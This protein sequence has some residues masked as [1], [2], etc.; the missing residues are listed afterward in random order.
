VLPL[1][2]GVSLA[3]AGAAGASGDAITLS[4]S[5]THPSGTTPLTITA[6]GSTSTANELVIVAAVPATQSQ[7]PSQYTGVAGGYWIDQQV[8]AT[9]TFSGVQSIPR[10]I[11][12]GSYD[13]CGWLVNQSGPTIV[14]TATP[15]AV[16]V[17]NPDSLTV[18]VAPASLIDGGSANV[19]VSGVADVDNPEVYVTEKPASEGGCA[20]AP[21]LD[22]GTPL[23]D[24]D[25]AFVNYD[26]FSDSQTEYPGNG[27]S[28]PDA[29]P[30]G[31]YT[32][33][34]WLIDADGSTTQPLAPV[35]EA[36]VTLLPPAGT[37]AF[38]VPE[39]VQ[40]GSRF[41]V[42]AD[43]ST[44][45]ADVGMYLDLK[46]LPARGPTCAASESLEPR[47]AQ[48]VIDDG[49]ATSTTASA[50]V[51][52]AGVYIACAWLEWP[53]GTIDG[54]FS[55]RFVALGSHQRPV[56]YSG[57][58]SQRLRHAGIG[59]ESVDGQVLS[60]TY[61]ARFACS[62]RGHKT[63][64]PVYATTFPAFGLTKGGR[65]ADTF[66][67]GNDHAKVAGRLRGRSAR[68]TFSEAY[69]S[70]GYACRSGTVSFTARRGRGSALDA[71]ET[72]GAAAHDSPVPAFGATSVMYFSRSASV[73]F[74]SVSPVTWL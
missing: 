49:H 6:A 55:G 31:R 1:A 51:R 35:A 50:K 13:I 53:H 17:S 63:S 44:G 23:A 21:S 18:S 54:P 46:P 59:F 38:S 9:G 37:L 25:P 3:F 22:R 74:W 7:C 34:G 36:T 43:L 15:L 4:A 14:A 26:S 61:H 52:S 28:G 60:L 69:T 68:G 33:C 27:K 48:L 8:S 47:A 12:H 71:A 65:F 73:N 29:L 57:G 72:R 40:A 67:Q 5:P 19:S 41:S 30:P 32:L 42:A 39:L 58:T 2:V 56:E 10:H 11:E 62:K 45:A 66:I 64:H 20:S 24:Y 16:T 70:G